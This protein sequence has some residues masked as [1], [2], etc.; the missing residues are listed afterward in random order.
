M[1]GSESD[2]AIVYSR[3]HIYPVLLGLDSSSVMVQ[4]AAVGWYVLPLRGSSAKDVLPC[5]RLTQQRADTSIVEKV[6]SRRDQ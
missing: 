2:C 6:V 4:G 1:A 5:S 3:R